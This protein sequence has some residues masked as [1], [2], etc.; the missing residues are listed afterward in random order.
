[1]A[2]EP[3][4]KLNDSVSEAADKAADKSPDSEQT[5]EQTSAC[6]EEKNSTEQ[7][8]EK[9]DPKICLK[10]SRILSAQTGECYYCREM[11]P[12]ALK[13]MNFLMLEWQRS[14]AGDPALRGNM[15]TRKAAA[16][17]QALIASA[18][19]ALA[20]LNDFIPVVSPLWYAGIGLVMAL[21]CFSFH[22]NSYTLILS[23]VANAGVFIFFL[24]LAVFKCIPQYIMAAFISGFI[25]SLAVLTICIVS[26]R[27]FKNKA[28][29]L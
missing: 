13:K 29:E 16:F 26:V 19:I 28:L 15:K 12:E 6:A 23:L 5:P 22:L 1:M 3:E 8:K 7:S 27:I 17:M 21:S 10:C 9:K 20:V 25:A 14:E 11:N 24:N 18:C 2:S 4:K